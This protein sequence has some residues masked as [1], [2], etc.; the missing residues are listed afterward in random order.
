MPHF[1]TDDAGWSY[2]WTDDDVLTVTT[3][4]LEPSARVLRLTT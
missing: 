3:D 4:T 2:T 1:P